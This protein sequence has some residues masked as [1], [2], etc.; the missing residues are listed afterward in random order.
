VSSNQV[1]SAAKRRSSRISKS[2]MLAVQSVD[3]SRNPYREEVTTGSIS[4]HGCTYRMR[5]E[6]RPGDIVVLDSGSGSTAHSGFPSR[7]RV[8]S[9]QRLNTPND[10]TYNV[11]VELEIAGNIWG[12]SSPPADWFPRQ[13]GNLLDSASHGRDLRVIPR[14]EPQRALARTEVATAVPVLKKNDAAAVLSPWFTNLM[15]ALSNQVQIAVCEI[16]EVTLANERK[17]LLDEFRFQIQ[18]EATG[19]IEHVIATSK[20]ELARRGLKVLN[21]GAQAI[22]KN[23]QGILV[24]AVEQQIEH[25]QQNLD[26]LAT[27][28]LERVERNL[29]ASRT[30]ATERFVLRLREQVAPV[31]EEA[32]ADFQKLVA[33]E[34]VFKQESQAI[35][36]QVTDQ[37]KNDANARV[38]QTHD[39]LQKNSASLVNQCN[40]KMVELSQ[41]FEKIARDSAQNMIAS[42]TDEGNKNLE[43]KAAEI[44]SHFTD[45][46]EGHV[47]NYLEFIGESIKEFPKKPPAA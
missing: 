47:R 19:T 11:G 46:L 35:Y 3:A 33:S 22:V 15:N 39:Q 40:E 2:I 18:N 6:P 27:G 36:R 21:E 32:R 1:A 8:K 9:I 4:C 16:A 30:K 5:H 31:M 45:Q 26:T 24:G 12:I 34:A 44:S 7:A 17:R 14:T 10:P 42:A 41:A 25:A 23:S 20:D 38:L 37:L 13:P 28:T 29:E 43:E